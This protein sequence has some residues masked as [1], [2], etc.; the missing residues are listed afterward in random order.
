MI[1]NAYFCKD[2]MQLLPVLVGMCLTVGTF[3][4]SHLRMQQCK[5]LQPRPE[6]QQRGDLK[7]SSWF[8]QL[9]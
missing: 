1:R 5:M 3:Q 2:T 7:E 8:R 4:A 6:A 9:K